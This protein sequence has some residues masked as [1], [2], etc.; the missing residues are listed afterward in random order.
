MIYADLNIN[1]NKGFFSE[2]KS[3]TNVFNTMLEMIL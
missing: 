2:I 1:Q 3:V